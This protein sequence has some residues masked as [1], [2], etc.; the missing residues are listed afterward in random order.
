MS[1]KWYV[2]QVRIDDFGGDLHTVE[3]ETDARPSL[4]TVAACD[5][6]DK[7]AEICAGLATGE[8]DYEGRCS[9]QD[10][11]AAYFYRVVERPAFFLDET[12][13]A[14]DFESAVSLMDDALREEV[15][16]DLAPCTDQLFIEEYAK[17]HADRFGDGFAPFV[18]GEW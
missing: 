12:G 2:Q 18:G 3:G 13:K 16:A 7:A 9:N 10:F 17:R 1:A 11:S 8:H 6:Y 4:K 5:S 15:H 14:Q